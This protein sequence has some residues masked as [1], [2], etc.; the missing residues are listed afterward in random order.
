MTGDLAK[1]YIGTYHAYVRTYSS[2]VGKVIYRLRTIFGSGLNVSYSDTSSATAVRSIQ[3]IDLGQIKIHPSTT[4]RPNDTIESVN[5]YLDVISEDDSLYCLYDEVY[6][7][8]IIPSDEWSGNFG[9]PS[10]IPGVTRYGGF[11]YYGNGLDVDGITNPRQY[12]ASQTI[13]SPSSPTPYTTYDDTYRYI[14]SEWARIASGEPIF[15]ANK[16]QRLWFMQ[17]KQ[18]AAGSFWFQ[19]CGKVCAQRSSRYIFARGSR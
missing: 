6:D 10:E 19:N 3:C 14:D 7:I 13:K 12:R 15:Q 16:D 11:L 18:S 5:I 8:I 2:Y 9:V 17:Y 4:I 1:Q